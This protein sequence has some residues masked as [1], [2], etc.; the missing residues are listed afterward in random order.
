MIE[1][2]TLTIIALVIFGL[3]GA[4]ALSIVPWACIGTGLFDKEKKYQS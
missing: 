1:L 4:V 2:P 3:G